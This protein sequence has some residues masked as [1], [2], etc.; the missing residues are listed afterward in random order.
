MGIWLFKW[1]LYILIFFVIRRGYVIIF[2]IRMCV[3]M[4]MLFRVKVVK[5]RGGLFYVFFC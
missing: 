3:E 1:G 2:Y 5:K 4:I